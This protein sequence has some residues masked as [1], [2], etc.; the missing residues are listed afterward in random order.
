MD[1]DTTEKCDFCRAKFDGPSSKKKARRHF[2]ERHAA[3]LRRT[4]ELL[5]RP[6]SARMWTTHRL[7]P[8]SEIAQPE[9][10]GADRCDLSTD[11]STPMETNTIV[12]IDDSPPPSVVGEDEHKDDVRTRTRG[13]VSTPLLERKD[14]TPIMFDP[15]VDD[16]VI[17]R[18][19]L[20]DL[21]DVDLTPLENGRATE[22]LPEEQF[23]SAQTEGGLLVDRGTS[24]ILIP[25]NGR[26]E[27]A[28][29]SGMVEARSG[30]TIQQ[31]TSIVSWAYR[32]PS[33]PNWT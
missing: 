18:R 21:E 10:R 28:S 19:I 6:P 26:M 1:A 30:L 33:F 24:P 9:G 29:Q 11:T 23:K 31:M 32:L 14:S 22:S 15:T 3:G 16:R 2:L 5:P 27:S 13:N 20:Q 8:S 17:L 4:I 7:V 25:F 12:V